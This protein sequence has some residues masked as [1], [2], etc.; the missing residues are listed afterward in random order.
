M[1]LIKLASGR[2][3]AGLASA[4][5]MLVATDACADF[6]GIFGVPSDA[7]IA[8]GT[9]VDV[10]NWRLSAVG[11]P[12]S[13]T[14][15]PAPG[16]GDALS[17]SIAALTNGVQTDF[18]LTISGPYAYE[19]VFN[20]NTVF[21][22]PGDSVYYLIDGTATA[23]AIQSGG[24]PGLPEPRSG[25]SPTLRLDPGTTFGWRVVS[26]PTPGE[27]TDNRVSFIMLSTTPV[28]EPGTWLLCAIGIG[29]FVVLRRR[30]NR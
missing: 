12:A 15:S 14:R 28:P 5:A 30:L 21:D 7:A 27:G 2:I 22:H 13:E 16:L 23:L 6:S 3:L 24:P 29:L 10:G 18:T 11:G 25:I 20:W 17:V 19:V 26:T 8:A 4:A 9:T 1:S